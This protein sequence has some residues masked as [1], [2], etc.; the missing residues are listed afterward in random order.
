M[1]KAVVDT[2]QRTVNCYA[3]YCYLSCI[4]IIRFS[5]TLTRR[6]FKKS[7]VFLVFSELGILFF[8]VFGCALVHE[9]YW[10]VFVIVAAKKAELKKDSAVGQ[11][12]LVSISPCFVAGVL[13]IPRWMAEP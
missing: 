3:V 11:P 9:L 10:S 8:L 1:W 4:F 6:F 7:S 5:H 13:G 12:W 2:R